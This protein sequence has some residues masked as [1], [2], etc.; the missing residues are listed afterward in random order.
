[1]II[2]YN[3]SPETINEKTKNVFVDVDKNVFSQDI[4]ATI[5]NM[6][7]EVFNQ[8]ITAKKQM[9]TFPKDSL[10]YKTL[11]AH[12]WSFKT[13]LNSTYGYMGYARARWYNFACGQ[14]IAT[15]SRMHTLEVLK[16]AEKKNLEVIY[17]DTDSA[18]IKYKNDKKEILDFLYFIN[19]KLPGIMELSLDGFYN[20]GLFVQKKGSEDV[21]KK[22]YALIDEENNMK[23]VGFE[24][25][26]HDWSKLAKETQKTILELILKNNDIDGAKEYVKKILKQIAEHSL[27]NELFIIYNQIRKNLGDYSS[28]GPAVNAAKKA[29]ARGEAIN[30][31]Y[32]GFI[33]SNTGKTI[34]D[35]AELYTYVKQGD[36]DSEYY[37]ENQIIPAVKNIFAVFNISEDQLRD[38]PSQKKLF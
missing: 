36:Y 9:K 7:K 10:E 32:V 20:R 1:V 13:I 2:S 38:K 30:E 21:A 31:S 12:Q 4:S 34:S 5:P 24:Y 18:F 15:T 27:P 23:I 16:E 28:I 8:R 19:N 25:V 17:A 35:K 22:K 3:I 14:S 33:V 11:F 37:I 26:R 6:L 29:I